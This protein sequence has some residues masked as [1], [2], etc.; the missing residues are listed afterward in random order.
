MVHPYTF[1]VMMDE[2]SSRVR[3]VHFNT[4][5]ME[6]HCTCKKFDFCSYLCSH[7]LRILSVKNVKKISYW[8]IS[9]RWTKHA[10]KNMYGGN[11]VVEFSQQYNIKAKVVFRNRDMEVEK[12]LTKLCVSKNH[13]LNE[14]ETNARVVIRSKNVKRSIIKELSSNDDNIVKQ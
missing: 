2:N 10:K 1:E 12:E 9:R 5:T 11:V 8:Y 6:I 4:I 14:N 3:I 13:K 7:A